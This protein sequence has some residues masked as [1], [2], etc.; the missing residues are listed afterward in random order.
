MLTRP[1]GWNLLCPFYFSSVLWRS[2]PVAS[3][4][5]K[6]ILPG[7]TAGQLSFARGTWLSNVPPSAKLGLNYDLPNP[8]LFVNSVLSKN[9]SCFGMFHGVGYLA[10]SNLSWEVS[11]WHRSAGSH[12][13][14]WVAGRAHLTQTPLPLG[15]EWKSGKSDSKTVWKV[16]GRVRQRCWSFLPPIIANWLNPG[17]IQHV[18]MLVREPVTC[19]VMII[20]YHSHQRQLGPG[21]SIT[22]LRCSQSPLHREGPLGAAWDTSTQ[23]VRNNSHLPCFWRSLFIYY[24]VSYEII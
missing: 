8:I 5:E 23:S 4:C 16:W 12:P 3:L 21:P 2:W 22:G 24:L 15:G 11:N 14:H 20:M 9:L 6:L 10:G 18:I 17:K 1:A 7:F 19:P 13:V